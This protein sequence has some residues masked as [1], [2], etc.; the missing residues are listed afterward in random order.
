MYI[1]LYYM[2]ICNIFNV[3]SSCQQITSVKAGLVGNPVEDDVKAQKFAYLSIVRVKS[4]VNY[5]KPLLLQVRY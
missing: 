2:F 5:L 1:F 4:K 3:C